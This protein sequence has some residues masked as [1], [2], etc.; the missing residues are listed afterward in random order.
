MGNQNESASG[1]DS[2]S[3]CDDPEVKEKQRKLR[4]EMLE[5]EAWLKKKRAEEAELRRKRD[6]DRVNGR[7]PGFL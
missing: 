4:E 5:K 2:E 6:T 7:M 1:S 3:D